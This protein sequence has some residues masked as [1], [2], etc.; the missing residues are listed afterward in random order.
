MTNTTRPRLLLTGH[1]TPHPPLEV[2]LK[3]AFDVQVLTDESDP[4]AFIAREG[5]NY[6]VL[7]TSGKNGANAAL[8]ASLKGLKAIAHFGVGYDNVDV[9]A[10]SKQGVVVS[11]TP[12]VLND[13]V[14]DLAIG[15]LVDTARGL[16]ASERFVRRGDWLKGA[17]RLT[18]RVSGKKLGIA[19]LGRI[20]RTIA[21]RAEGFD[22]DIRYY[23]RN[24]VADVSYQHEKSLV[25]LA[26]WCD[27][28]MVV[29]S[30]GASTKHLVSA[31]VID[32]LGPNSYL[33]NV[34]RGTVVDEEA[35]LRALQQNKIAGAGLDVFTDEPNVPTAFMDLD[36]VVLLPHIAS[37]THETRKAMGD[38]VF[39]NVESFFKTGKLVTPV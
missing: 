25:E 4:A 8:I 9:T 30:G 15:L 19:G 13:C 21:K 31:E 6:P 5:A 7:V 27:F 10:A 23:S 12:D 26:K 3:A 22:M 11:N 32:A 16:S 17:F 36:N 34:S 28:L 14:A 33:V 18:T 38:L 37:G 1:I 39:A 20:G 29:V 35:L 24:P 2:Q